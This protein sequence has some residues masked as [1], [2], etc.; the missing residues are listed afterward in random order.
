[1]NRNIATAKLSPA[2]GTYDVP[3]LQKRLGGEGDDDGVDESEEEES[4]ED[5]Y[6]FDDDE[7]EEE[8]DDSCPPGCDIGFYEKT[9]ELREQRLDHE[10][11]LTEI[12][13]A[14]DDLKRN[15]D[16]QVRCPLRYTVEHPSIYIY[17]R[18][19]RCDC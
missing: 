7:E 2:P 12:Q 8:V 13:K 11:S 10:E 18:G 15:L 1:M 3:T 17:P 4:E 5:D 19:N 6:D 16:R 9:L 14:A